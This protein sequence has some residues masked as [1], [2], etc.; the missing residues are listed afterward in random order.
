[1]H[2]K[3]Q[4]VATAIIAMS[5]QSAESHSHRLGYLQAQIAWCAED[6]VEWE[7]FKKR[8]QDAAKAREAALTPALEAK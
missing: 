4:D 5:P 6:P 7:R 3:P 2:I 8:L 1:M